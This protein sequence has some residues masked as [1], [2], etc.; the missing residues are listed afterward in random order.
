MR[1]NRRSQDKYSRRRPIDDLLGP[2]STFAPKARGIGSRK[3]KEGQTGFRNLKQGQTPVDAVLGGGEAPVSE[4]NPWTNPFMEVYETTKAGAMTNLEEMQKSMAE[5]FAHRGGYFGGKHAIGQAEMATKT[6]TALDQLLSQTALGAEQMQYE[7]WK[8]AE[9]QK[10][11]LMNLIPLLLGTETSENIVQMPGQ[12][13][14]SM[15][16]NLLGMGAGAFTGGLGSGLGTSM[17][18]K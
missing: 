1:N 13:T 11:N 8:R 16:G 7:D 9:A 4:E 6:G 10:M 17:G 15:F 14:S 3:P 12:G 5:K 18:T 2:Q